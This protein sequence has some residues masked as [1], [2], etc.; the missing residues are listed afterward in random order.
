MGYIH[1]SSNA[2]G[3]QPPPGATGDPETPPSDPIKPP[4]VAD[5]LEDDEPEAENGAS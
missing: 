2:P 3:D 5:S 1:A 4:T